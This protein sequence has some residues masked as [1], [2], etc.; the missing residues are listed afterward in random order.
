MVNEAMNA[1][2]AVIVSDDVGCQEDLVREGETGGGL[3]RQETSRAF[4]RRR[5]SECWGA[6]NGDPHGGVQGT[7]RSIQFRSWKL[8]G[9]ASKAGFDVF[10]IPYRGPERGGRRP[11][12][13]AHDEVN[14]A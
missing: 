13:A 6:R 5:S 2:R 12:A 11:A 10:P 3:L 1:G 8:R 9:S 14:D 4:W 7:H